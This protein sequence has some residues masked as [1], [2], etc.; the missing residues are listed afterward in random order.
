MKLPEHPIGGS[1]A[2]RCIECP[3]SYALINQIGPEVSE[4]PDYQK[5]GTMAHALAAHCLDNN[6][7]CWESLEHFPEATSADAVQFYLDYVRSRGGTRV[8][9]HAISNPK[10]HP[11]A[12]GRM[13]CAI[14][15]PLP[16]EG[17][18][19]CKLEIDDYKHGL[20]VQVAVEHN[21]QERYYAFNFAAGDDWPVDWPRLADMDWVRLVI[22]QPRGFDVGGPVRS[23]VVRWGDIVNWAYNKLL[24]AMKKAEAGAPEYKMGGW[25]RFCPAK[26]ACP[27]M[28][29]LGNDA[30][31]A[32]TGLG[33]KAIDPVLGTVT[34]PEEQLPTF[35]D[36]W[37][38]EWYG[39]LPMLRMFIKAINDETERRVKDGK[40][41]TTAK[42]VNQIVHRA[43]KAGA[44]APVLDPVLGIEAPS[45]M[46]TILGDEAWEPRALRSPAQI[47]KLGSAG[48][49]FVAEYAEMPVAPLT[50][51]PM[52][53]RRPAQK[54]Q[55][56]EEIFKGLTTPAA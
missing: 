24:P 46:L 28:R 41:I 30:G 11:L 23:V 42:L 6:L 33:E 55:T 53:D 2:E 26:L 54:P 47:E 35:D 10:F 17:E 40:L 29:S 16:I 27:E 32:W 25:C 1:S 38:S 39:R 43:W 4:A 19:V 44:T 14:L 36:A 45:P 3:G 51:A 9:E 12:Y 20:G 34:A 21:V 18:P 48:K 22:V 5:E 7:D 37:I 31:F 50:V 49:A 56:N 8:V 15:D 13:D 52:S